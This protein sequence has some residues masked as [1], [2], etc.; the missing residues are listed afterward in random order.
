[1]YYKIYKN[2]S[3][4][5]CEIVLVGD[6]RGLFKLLYKNSYS[7]KI[8]KFKI[9]PEWILASDNIDV[10]DEVE[11]QLGEY[12]RDERKL[13]DLKLNLEGT[14]FQKKVWR[15]LQRIPY[16]KTVTYKDIAE[17]IGNPK[18]CRAVGNANNKN[19]IPL[20]IPCHR[21][22]PASGGVGGFAGGTPLKQKLLKLENTI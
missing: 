17:E 19:P 6:E 10:F 21:V 3:K 14:D 2:Y 16:G 11:N 7:E 12:F 20:I 15:S 18:A 9:N 8:G 4:E 1:M 5:F 22:I 13:F